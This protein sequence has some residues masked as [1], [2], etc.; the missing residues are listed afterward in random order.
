MRCR[1]NRNTLTREKFNTRLSFQDKSSG[2]KMNK[3]LETE[4]SSTENVIPDWCQFMNCGY[5]CRG[6][7]SLLQNINHCT[8]SF[9]E[10]IWLP[11]KKNNLLNCYVCSRPASLSSTDLNNIVDTGTLTNIHQTLNP[12]I[13]QYN[14]F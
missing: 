6:L 2:Q 12:N 7:R 3:D 14:F 4:S 5:R 11:K 1:R 13:R 8:T 9:T 10:A